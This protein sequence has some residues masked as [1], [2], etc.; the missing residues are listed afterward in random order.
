M[1]LATSTRYRINKELNLN[2]S[3]QNHSVS[4]TRTAY[5]MAQQKLLQVSDEEM[6]SNFVKLLDEREKMN[7]SF[8]Y[9]EPRRFG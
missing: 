4:P 6:I 7:D 2:R 5:I 8:Q 3:L 9:G 1:S